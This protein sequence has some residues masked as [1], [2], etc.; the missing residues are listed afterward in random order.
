[1]LEITNLETRYGRIRALQ[2]ISIQVE[3]HEVVAAL[4]AN[5]AGKQ[6]Y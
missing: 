2:E 3:S 6:P 5:G 4:G 1:M